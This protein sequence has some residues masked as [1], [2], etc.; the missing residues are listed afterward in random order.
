MADV[1]I[2][3]ARTDREKARQLAK[4][5][6]EQGL[7]VWWDR[8]IV[9][10]QRFD[11]V[12]EQEIDSA[13]CIVVLW[14]QESTA[15]SWVKA[16][17]AEGARRNA[18]VP[19][20]VEAVQIPLEFRRIQTANLT[21]WTGRGPG[22]ELNELLGAVRVTLRGRQQEPVRVTAAPQEQP[23]KQPWR[24]EL[25]EARSYTFRSFRVILEQESHIV[26]YQY[27][28]YTWAKALVDGREV[29]KRFV[30]SFGGFTG[31]LAFTLSDGRDKLPAMIQ[32]QSGA[33]S[34]AMKNL[35]LFVGDRILYDGP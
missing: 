13:R 30:I 24:A 6:E 19:V 23:L 29:A 9:P 5:L 7:S 35:R 28:A 1:F 34:E 21:H 32:V 11:E 12:I 26:T 14:S 22:P 2:S 16:E 10:G 15:S 20:L 33:W 3:Y 18:L 25:I 31:T 4:L 17:A 27:Q 8:E